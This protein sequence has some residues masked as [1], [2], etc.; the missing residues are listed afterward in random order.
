M[1]RTTMF[2]SHWDNAYFIV[3]KEG[4]TGCG[5]TAEECM[6][7]YMEQVQSD[8]IKVWDLPKAER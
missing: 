8:A 6:E 2:Y 1:T 7:D 4:R 3:D 5:D